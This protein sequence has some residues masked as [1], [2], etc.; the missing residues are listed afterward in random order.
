MRLSQHAQGVIRRTVKEIFGDQASVSLFGSRLDD[1]A[2]GGDID[3]LV[4][5]PVLV[6]DAR[7]KTLTLVARLQIRLGDQ[8]IDVIYLG[9][10]STPQPVH[11]EALRTGKTL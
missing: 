8:P 10:D 6:K 11:E 3:L 1:A 2:R 5:S 4:Q 9:P 7:R